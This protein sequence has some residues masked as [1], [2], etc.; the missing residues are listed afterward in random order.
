AP[1]MELKILNRWHSL[2][3][4]LMNWYFDRIVDK[5]NK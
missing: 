2:L 1:G 3:S 4:P 5:T